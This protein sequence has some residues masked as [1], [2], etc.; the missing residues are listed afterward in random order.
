MRAISWNVVLAALLLISSFALPHSPLSSALV[1]AA[2]IVVGVVSLA[3]GGK[4]ELRYVNALIAVALGFLSLLLPDMGEPARL[5]TAVLAAVVF[6]LSLVSPR[7]ART[8][9]ATQSR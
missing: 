4:P 2:G 1:F 5:G 6:A 3:S 9:H 8:E 7:H